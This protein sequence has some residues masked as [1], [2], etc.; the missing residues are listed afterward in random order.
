LD[1]DLTPFLAYTL[2]QLVCA[3]AHCL[4]SFPS[5]HPYSSYAFQLLATARRKDPRLSGVRVRHAVELLESLAGTQIKV[6]EVLERQAWA[7]KWQLSEVK[8]VLRMLQKSAVENKA[9]LA[10]QVR[11]RGVRRVDVWLRVK[12]LHV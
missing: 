3:P 9:D 2:A 11:N 1:Q 8:A 7:T 6:K 4:P 10:R 12:D 5:R